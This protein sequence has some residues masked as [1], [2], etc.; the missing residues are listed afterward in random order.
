MTNSSSIINILILYGALQ[1]FFIS[2]VLLIPK[3]RSLF[4]KLFSSLLI[5]EGIILFE[6]L[7]VET[8]II[9]SVPHL[10][11]ISYP[12]SFLKPPLILFM[13]YT[14][15][16]RNYE[17]QKKS[18][19]HLMPFGLMLILNLPFYFMS[20]TEKL[21]WVK[22]FMEKIPSYQSF[23][24]YFTLSFFLYIGIYIFLALKILTRFRLQVLNN[25]TVNWYRFILIAYSIFLL[26]HLFYFALQPL[27]GLNFGL[28]NQLSMLVMTFIIQSIAFKLIGKSTLLSSTP[29]DLSD[30]Q[31]RKENEDL[32]IAQFEQNK[33][34]LIDDMNLQ[35]FAESVGLSISDVSLII[36]QKFNISFKKLVAFYRIKEAKDLIQQSD[37]TKVRLIDIAYQSGFNNKVS[38]YRAFKEFE[39][40][41]P[42]DYLQ[43]VKKHKKS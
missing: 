34:H 13:A 15:T 28:I 12:I 42:S 19:L 26:I 37:K 29:P 24:F 30:L 25:A 39:Q 43:S 41:T 14:I 23:D 10:L 18:Y 31:K 36:N 27:G 40:T 16:D 20:G 22:E 2:L 17:I 1:A 33:I 3:N 35:K 9:N 4:N 21:N 8:A 7:L 38:F 11:G 5:I 32:I 6:R